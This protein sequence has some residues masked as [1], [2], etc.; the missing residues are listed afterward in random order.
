[1]SRIRSKDTAPEMSVRRL[2]HGMGFRYR[3][4]VHKLPGRPDLVFPKLKKIIQVHGCFFHQ[5]EGC[6]AAHVRLSRTNYWLPKL[7]RNK[8]RDVETEKNL[9]ERG[10]DVLTLWGCEVKDADTLWGRLRMFLSGN[11]WKPVKVP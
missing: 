2:V 4:H 1:M 8:Q 7:E 3:L 10:W 6:K 11:S 9:R 5:H